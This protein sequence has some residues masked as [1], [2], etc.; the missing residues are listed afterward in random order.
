LALLHG[1]NEGGLCRKL[2]EKGAALGEEEGEVVLNVC[3]HVVVT[4]LLVSVRQNISE[5]DQFRRIRDPDIGVDQQRTPHR[6]A[7]RDEETF[8][9]HSQD[10]VC[11]VATAL[12]PAV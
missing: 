8:Y 11:F 9:R 5:R 4:D 10:L 6:F 12:L 3:P 1:P 2:A 7:L